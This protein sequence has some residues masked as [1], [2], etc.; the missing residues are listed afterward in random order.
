MD[1]DFFACS[2]LESS[3]SITLAEKGGKT[4]EVIV[5]HEAF[6][7]IA[8]MNPGGD[9]GKKELSPALSNRF[10]TIW[11]PPMEDEA[12]LKAIL[13][14]RLLEPELRQLVTPLLLHFW[15][16]YKSQIAPL[17]RQ[18]LSV[19]DLLTWI[20]FLN[21]TAPL[22]GPYTAYGHGAHVAFLDGIGLGVGL[23]EEVSSLRTDA[24][25]SLSLYWLTLSL[26]FIYPENNLSCLKFECRHQ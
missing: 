5:A 25:Y 21:S 26:A 20:Q 19:R 9:Y 7:I 13:E 12:E 11:V 17:A 4:A 23:S 1:I 2:V 15:R 18:V 14:A 8:T 10:T 3:R 16:F 22:T 24:S 6:R